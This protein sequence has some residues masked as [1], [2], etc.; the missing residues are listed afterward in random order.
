M[1][2]EFTIKKSDEVRVTIKKTD[3]IRVNHEKKKIGK[4]S[5]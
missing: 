5:P 4:I 2:W 3:G 1:G